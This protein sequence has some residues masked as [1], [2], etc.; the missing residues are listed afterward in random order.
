MEVLHYVSHGNDRF[1]TLLDGLKDRA[2]RVAILKRIDRVED[3]NFGDQRFVGEGVFE[4]RVHFGPGY[5]VYYGLDGPRLVL[6][7]CGGDKA[8]QHRD[9]REAKELWAEYRRLK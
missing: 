8:T 3:G 6:L 1:G 2:A 5:R 9:V 4:I 7:L